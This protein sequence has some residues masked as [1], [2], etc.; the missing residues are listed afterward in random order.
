MPI[1]YSLTQATFLPL[2]GAVLAYFLG[3]RLLRRIGWLAFAL[4]SYSSLLLGLSY[5][6]PAGGFPLLERFGWTSVPG[7]SFGLLGDGLS[8]PVALVMNVAAAAVAVY[9][10]PYMARRMA[11]LYGEE[12]GSFWGLYYANYLL[13]AAGLTGVA[14]ATNLIE[15]YIFV[16]LIL[17]PAY[18]LLGL[19]G[20]VDR[21]RIALM[22]FIWNQLGAFIFLAGILVAWFGTRSFDIAALGAL[23]GPLAL[24]V[25]GLMLL[26]WLIKMATFG[27]HVWLPFA[28][29]EFPSSVAAI[30]AITGLGSYVLTRLLVLNL[31]SSFQQLAH[32]IILLAVV[33]L[34]YGGALAL[35][36]EDINRLY[37]WSTVSQTAYLLLGLASLSALGI[38]GSIFLF[39]AQVLGKAVLFCVAGILVTQTGLRQMGR[40]GGYAARMP[41]TALLALGA[42]LIISAVPPTLG[43]QGEWLLFTGL[44]GWALYGPPFSLALGFAALL[45]TMLTVAYTL[46]AVKRIFF[47]PLSGEAGELSEA[48]KSMTLP[49]LALLA[50]AL[51]LGIYPEPLLGPLYRYLASALPSGLPLGG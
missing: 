33:T 3:G 30:S 45:G 20:Q 42:S 12:R 26:G 13:F 28:Y 19:F 21:Q 4:L 46:W 22:Y 24:L 39:L 27:F 40:M 31:Y 36:Q 1:P 18:L 38:A 44:L 11:A 7:L 47:G 35:A 23:G 43:F 15:L 50:L 51:L 16:E 32:L 37:A 34:L 29:G 17:I 14:L 48:P 25:T 49:L 2:A 5:L 41:L 9:S 8:L 10:M 6:E